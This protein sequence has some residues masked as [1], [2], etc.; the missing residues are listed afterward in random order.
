MI[1]EGVAPRITLY[2][3]KD[4]T[5]T[6]NVAVT[7]SLEYSRED[8]RVDTD[9]N[10]LGAPFRFQTVPSDFDVVWTDP[11]QCTVHLSEYE[12]ECH[13][14]TRTG[15]WIRIGCLTYY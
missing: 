10:D 3:T 5:D 7:P 8:S 1:H 9:H 2:I 13:N 6:N 14:T 4:G 11:K 15:I 12:Y